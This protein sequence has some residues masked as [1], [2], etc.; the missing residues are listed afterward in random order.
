[1]SIEQAAKLLLPMVRRLKQATM[2]ELEESTGMGRRKLRFH[3]G[4]LVK[5]DR[6]ARHGMGRGTYYTIKR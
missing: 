4:Q 2:Q 3:I 6:L 1:M 5:N